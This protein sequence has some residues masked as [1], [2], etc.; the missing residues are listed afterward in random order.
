MARAFAALI[1]YLACVAAQARGAAVAEARRLDEPGSHWADEIV[2]QLAVSR[3]A[4]AEKL[5]DMC[6]KIRLQAADHV[7]RP[8]EIPWAPKEIDLWQPRYAPGFWT[9]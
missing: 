3:H 1:V 7:M 5:D 9:R 6:W 8:W 2:C 4:A